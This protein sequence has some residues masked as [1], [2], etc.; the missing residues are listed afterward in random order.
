M[1]NR[2]PLAILSSNGSIVIKR[3]TK[4]QIEQTIKRSIFE[5][6]R[7]KLTSIIPI[8]NIKPEL[9]SFNNNVAMAIIEFKKNKNHKN[10]RNC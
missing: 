3:E 1:R 6:N 9:I 8:K 4:E 7:A 2:I 10:K 5:K